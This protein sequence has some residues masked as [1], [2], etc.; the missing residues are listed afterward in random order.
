MNMQ[1]LQQHFGETLM[2]VYEYKRWQDVFWVVVLSDIDLMTL[3]SKKIDSNVIFFTQKDIL[4]GSDVFPLELAFIRQ[5]SQLLHG[6]D[7]L[8]KIVFSRAAIR[9]QLEYE[10]RSKTIMWRQLALSR[11]PKTKLLQAVWEQLVLFIG[12]V[13]LVKEQNFSS[14]WEVNLTRAEKSIGQEF[15]SFRA[16]LS[17]DPKQKISKSEELS[18]MQAIHQD[19]VQL[20]SIINHLSV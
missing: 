8:A 4:E 1:D 20:T 10:L 3:P 17:R 15:L 19:L 11:K 18:M 12:G 14:D 2:S 7:I 5:R 16:A 13:I 9:N 6:T